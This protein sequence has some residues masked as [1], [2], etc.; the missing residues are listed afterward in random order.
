MKP[1]SFSHFSKWNTARPFHFAD[2]GFDQCFRA[3]FHLFH[4]EPGSEGG[5]SVTKSQSL[6]ADQLTPTAGNRQGE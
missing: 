5:A 1:G 2:R 3:W 4:L 6:R